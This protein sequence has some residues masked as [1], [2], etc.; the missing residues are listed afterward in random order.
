VVL[1]QLMRWLL[2]NPQAAG[3]HP[4]LIAGLSEPRLAR[5]LA[6]IHAAPGQAWTLERM[7]QAAGMSRTR[8]ATLFRQVLGETP[9]DYLADWRLSLARTALSQ[10]RPIKQLAGEL[11]YANPSALSRAFAARTGQSPR[12]WLRASSAASADRTGT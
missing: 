9:A 1:I 6:Q 11:G 2:D 7:A 8:F 5:C 12:E 3:V 4:G 10:G